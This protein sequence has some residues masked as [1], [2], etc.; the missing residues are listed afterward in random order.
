MEKR[1]RMHLDAAPVP[2]THDSFLL[3]SRDVVIN[4]SHAG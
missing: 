1:R 4:I 3:M 2:Q